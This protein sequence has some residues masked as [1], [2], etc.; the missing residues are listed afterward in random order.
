M[1]YKGYV[2]AEI[3]PLPD[4]DTAAEKTITFLKHYI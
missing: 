2:S 1:G 3:L 4:P